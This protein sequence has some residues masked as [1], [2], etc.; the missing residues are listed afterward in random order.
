MRILTFIAGALLMLAGVWCF[1]HP[2]ATFLSLAFVLGWAMVFGGAVDILAFIPNRKQLGT[3]GWQLANGALTL[4]LG[5]L[6]LCNLLITD[7]VLV[8]FFGMWVMFSGVLRC[9]ASFGLRA[10]GIPG[11]YWSLVMGAVSVAAGVYA[12]LNPLVA[13]LAMVLLLGAFFIIQGVNLFIAGLQM[14][15]LRAQMTL[16]SR[17]TEGI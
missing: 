14:G 6:V 2:G 3:S 11:W 15:A 17:E 13:G 4:L 12:F 7:A 1:A 5:I 9:V 16:H 10:M 8:F